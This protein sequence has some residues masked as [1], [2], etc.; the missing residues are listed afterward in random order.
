[1]QII[2]TATS[3]LL[4]LHKPMIKVKGLQGVFLA[5]LVVPDVCKGQETQIWDWAQAFFSQL[6]GGCQ[7]VVSAGAPSRLCVAGDGQSVSRHV[8][9]T[10]EVSVFCI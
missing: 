5:R 8:A 3:E 7:V 1:V 6:F 2:G 10:R 4:S 9:G